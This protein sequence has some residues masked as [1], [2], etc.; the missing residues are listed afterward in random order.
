[1]DISFSNF[2]LIS[3]FDSSFINAFE[4]FFKPFEVLGGIVKDYIYGC[5][6]VAKF[7]YWLLYMLS[8]WLLHIQ[9]MAF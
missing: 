2:W 4:T 8:I 6:F 7:N 5:S 1:M 9:Q 3:K